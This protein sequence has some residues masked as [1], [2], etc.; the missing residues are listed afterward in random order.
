MFKYNYYF[1]VF[2]RLFYATVN[3]VPRYGLVLEI[4]YS[5]LLT[6][7]TSQ[8]RQNYIKQFSLVVNTSSIIE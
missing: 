8:K 2:L 3:N 1:T 7:L 4:N 6:N 5:V